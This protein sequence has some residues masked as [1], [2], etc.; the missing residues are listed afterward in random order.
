MNEKETSRI[1]NGTEYW[2]CV[3]VSNCAHAC[4]ILFEIKK[5]KKSGK[6]KRIRRYLVCAF[7]VHIYVT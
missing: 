6:R 5:E 7:F 2:W 4:Q 3:Y 1:Q